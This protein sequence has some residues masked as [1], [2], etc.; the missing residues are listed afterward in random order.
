MASKL[1]QSLKNM[2]KGPSLGSRV[3]DLGV[4]YTLRFYEKWVLP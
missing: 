1:L 2:G 4:D 3:Y